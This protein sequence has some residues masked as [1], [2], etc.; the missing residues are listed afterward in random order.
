MN[1][2]IDSGRLGLLTHGALAIV[3]IIEGISSKSNL[4]RLLAGCVVGWHVWAVIYH[5]K[6][7]NNG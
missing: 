3:G 4:R 7:I 1:D 6:E 2:P 5:M